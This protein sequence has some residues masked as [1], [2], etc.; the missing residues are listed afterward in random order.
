MNKDG[1]AIKRIQNRFDCCGFNSLKDR[2]WPFPDKEVGVGECQKRYDR[3]QSCAGPWRQAEQINAGLLFTIAAVIF[4]IKVC[5]LCYQNNPMLTNIS[6][7]RSFTSS[8][9]QLTP[10]PFHGFYHH[11]SNV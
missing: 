5:G 10:L 11:P 3:T 1:A 7:L 4:V 6:S 8:L 2:A 9:T